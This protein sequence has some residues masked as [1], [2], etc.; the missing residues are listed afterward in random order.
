MNKVA[1]DFDE[2][3]LRLVVGDLRGG[4]ICITD[5]AVLPLQVDG[6]GRDAAAVLKEAITERGLAGSEAMI[7]I[8]RGRAELRELQLPPV[9][10]DEL[11]DMVRFQ[12]IRSFASSGES[13]QVD[14]LVTERSETGI[15][16]IAAA[17]SP[18]GIHEIKQL[19][20]IAS[21]EP[22]RITLRP[23]SSA[24]LY[25]TDKIS[26]S[27]KNAVLVDLLGDDAEIVVTQHGHVIFVRSVRMPASGPARSRSLV[28]EL[29]R[30]LVACGDEA[31]PDRVVLWGK[32][33]VHQ[34]DRKLLSGACGTDVDV[35]DPFDLVSLDAALATSLP[36]HV[37]R[38]A[39]LVGLL[40]ADN[41]HPE[42]LIDFLNPRK[43]PEVK[44]NHFRTGMLVAIPVVLL[45]FLGY[46]AYS[47]ISGLNQ[48]I[49][50][51]NQANGQMK[52]AVDAA[53]ESIQRTEQIDQFLDGNVQWLD[54]IERL[55]QRMPG[56]DEMIIRSI[57]ASAGGREGGGQFVVTG[58][59]IRPD[60][61]DDF[62][63]ALRDDRHSVVGDGASEDK[64]E[65]LYRWGF[66]ETITIEA[67]KVRNRRYERILELLN[68]ETT[69]LP[70]SE[71]R[72]E[73]AP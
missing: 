29:K 26:K 35:V 59:A 38:F 15:E 18:K 7:T 63:K 25:L 3:E 8:G 1:I 56:S 31:K 11:P 55:A 23:L 36:G 69:P 14:Y 39:P 44:P 2:H 67:E 20:R 40:V 13:A 16:V 28:G 49:A 50:A 42:R 73:V 22:T 70:Q 52:P 62:E 30:S 64:S 53:L 41:H 21:L 47:R 34:E 71:S 54:E 45:A 48:E 10:E 61:I 9:P 6:V 32:E 12:A 33:S 57:S 51:L 58:G 43:R 68:Q 19:C 27:D 5:V 37:G 72:R 60:A 17:I 65:N 46:L 24:S 4:K 66:T